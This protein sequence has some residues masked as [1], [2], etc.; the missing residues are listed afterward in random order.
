MLYQIKVTDN[1]TRLRT[2]G[3]GSKIKKHILA[4][5]WCIVWCNFGENEVSNS[6]LPFKFYTKQSNYV[7]DI[8]VGERNEPLVKLWNIFWFFLVYLFAICFKTVVKYMFS[9][10]I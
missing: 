6:E 10:K 7:F 9:V 5:F 2:T 1:G 8:P 4:N 3:P